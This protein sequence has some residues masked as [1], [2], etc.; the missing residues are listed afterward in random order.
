MEKSVM[1][2]QVKK[3]AFNP[4]LPNYE[5]V[6]DG[7]PYVFGRRIY[8][9]G[10]HDK[11]NGDKFCP[12]DYVCWSAPIT[13][14]GDWK[15]E[16]VIYRKTQD[17]KNKNGAS[18]LNAPDVQLGP[19]E[20][21]YLYYV[22]SRLTVISV[23][24]SDHPEGPFEFYGYVRYSDGVL[25]GEKRTDAYNFDP[26][27][28]MDE[29]ES[30]WLYSGF[31]PKKG[32]LRTIMGM[33]GKLDGAYGM[34]LEKDM[35]TIK[36]KPRVVAPGPLISPGTDFEGHAFY[37]ASSMRKIQG[38]Y[39]FVY[40]SELSHELCYALGE[41]P[42]GPFRYGGTLISIGDIGLNGNTETKNYL[43][44][45]HG[46]M[47]KIQNQWY[48][49]YHRQTNRQKCCRQGCAEKITILPNGLIP[50]AEMTSC[51]LN[52]VPLVGTGCY[53][54]RIAC[55]LMSDKG[56]CFYKK[57]HEKDKQ[58]IHP[59]FTQSGEDR[60]EIGDQYIAN[61]KDGSMA[62]YKYF[63]FWFPV[64]IA[65][66]VRGKGSGIMEVRT[67][68]AGNPV[69]EITLSDSESWNKFSANTVAALE[70]TQ[71]LYF[72]YR[73]TGTFDFKNFILETE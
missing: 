68:P 63:S 33:R 1:N 18:N 19:D 25:Y 14:L 35:L 16:G 29:D 72:T 73:G 45:T 53:E 37:E 31:A 11:F 70:G 5:Y 55:H 32:M 24:V 52:Q 51:G 62:G 58:E 56:A 42:L 23:A 54:A 57:T 4:Y 44:N 40:S 27:V 50:Q 17:P 67:E 48:I 71:A 2:R 12:G 15:Y 60:E 69:A 43:G 30:I 66:T 3:Q 46:G 59:Y 49:F 61:M 8:V 26:A 13:D 39:Y 22:A 28:F 36:G 65:V 41:S 7:E 38:K 64:R 20:R 10:S 9:Y 47:V 34:E 21:Y 6:P